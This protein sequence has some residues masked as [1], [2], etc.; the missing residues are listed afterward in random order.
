MVASALTCFL[1]IHTM[2]GCVGE[3][4]EDG[5]QRMSMRQ[6]IGHHMKYHSL[7]LV[8]QDSLQCVSNKPVNT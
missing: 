1:L 5:T 8:T 6:R 4:V 3:L 7:P 2:V